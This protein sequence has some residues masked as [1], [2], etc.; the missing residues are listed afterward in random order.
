MSGGDNTTAMDVDDEA[1][2]S[3]APTIHDLLTQRVDDLLSVK[4]AISW[5]TIEEYGTLSRQ[6]KFLKGLEPKEFPPDDSQL[7]RCGMAIYSLEG[8]PGGS[9][10]L[11]LQKRTS[12]VLI[13]RSFYAD[14]YDTI[15]GRWE[16]NSR[17]KIILTGNS[18]T[19]KSWFQVSFLR[20]LLT[21]MD[22]E[23]DP[24]FHFVVRQVGTAFFLIDLK[25]CT[26]YKI[27]GTEDIIDTFLDVHGRIL[28]MYEP[29]TNV[30]QPP[31]LT[32]AAS[33]STLPPRPTRIKE[34]K[35]SGVL[36]LYMP[37][38]EYN[39]LELIAQE[40]TMDLALLDKNYGLFGGIVRH[41]LEQDS[42]YVDNVLGDVKKRCAAV[43]AEILRSIN[44][45]IDDDPTSAERHNVSGFVVCY[46]DIPREGEQRFTTYSLTMT[47]EYARAEVYNMMNLSSVREHLDMMVSHLASTSRDI[48]GKDLEVSAVNMLA[49]GP[50][51]VAW[52]YH[53]VGGNAGSNPLKLFH[54]KRKINREDQFDKSLVNYPTDTQ[55]PLADFFLMIDEVWWAFQTTWQIDHAFKLATLLKFRNI[56]G[57]SH[58]EPLN[59]LFVNPSHADKYKRRSKDKYLVGG[60]GAIDK[61]I[62]DSNGQNLLNANEVAIMWNNTNIYV[63][64][65]IEGWKE[66]I[67]NFEGME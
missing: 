5:L 3:S 12:N 52:E 67:R 33:L 19:G 14:L 61:P 16:K 51:T 2:S 37:V 58:K 55:F 36:F 18:G 54:T 32:S 26:G 23:D 56:L 10:F 8:S 45:G 66:A 21:D 17:E 64:C 25:T 59:I 28:Y 7:S 47:S 39:E 6:L 49:A 27:T 22:K 38:W 34:Y 65:P 20:R 50:K 29:K 31:L 60:T 13:E 43:K 4:E 57:L 46:T 41:T 1:R 63:A 42:L 44:T 9:Q 40:E 48:T 15:V 11:N 62:L 53:A 35:K 30:D 24:P